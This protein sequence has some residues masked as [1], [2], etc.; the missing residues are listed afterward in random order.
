MSLGVILFLLWSALL[1]LATYEAVRVI[2]SSDRLFFSLFIAARILVALGFIALMTSNI[3]PGGDGLRYRDAAQSLAFHST[4]RLADIAREWEE[5][6]YVPYIAISSYFELLGSTYF[7]GICQAIVHLLG[8]VLLFDA[9]RRCTTN[10]RTAKLMAVIYG[11]LPILDYYSHVYLRDIYLSLA[12]AWFMYG[13]TRPRR[14]DTLLHMAASLILMACIR[15]QYLPFFLVGAAVFFAVR[16]GRGRYLPI[17]G[18][19]LV[20][21]FLFEQQAYYFSPERLVPYLIEAGTIESDPS[22]QY[23]SVNAA[24]YFTIGNW[25][26]TLL[27]LFGPFHFFY[28]PEYLFVEYRGDYVERF[29]EGLSGLVFA[30]LLLSSISALAEKMTARFRRQQ[31]VLSADEYSSESHRNLQLAA[32]L[33]CSQVIATGLVIFF[34]LSVLLTFLGY[35]RW[36]MPLLPLYFVL[37]VALGVDAR[38]FF[39]A[40]FLVGL[41]FIGSLFLASI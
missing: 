17:L 26:K 3:N 11:F 23:S 20:G 7:V 15:F 27:G 22:L 34:S 37:A 25:L 38:R 39:K 1:G 19:A 29:T 12:S 28:G 32:R 10:I 4:T 18:V 13:V 2:R 5:I 36:R 24:D 16:G 30:T 6:R 33:K 40:A 9:V 8:A 21:W 14:R 41:A 31:A 35:N